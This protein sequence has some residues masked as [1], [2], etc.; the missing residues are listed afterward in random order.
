MI[1]PFW[2]AS[3]S[4]GATTRRQSGGIFSRHDRRAPT[5]RNRLVENSPGVATPPPTTTT[6]NLETEVSRLNEESAKKD[7]II[8]ELEAEK[9]KMDKRITNLELGIEF[10]TLSSGLGMT[11]TDLRALDAEYE[12]LKLDSASV[13]SDLDAAQ[14]LATS[15]DKELKDVR[16]LLQN[17]E[18]TVEILRAEN[19][20]LELSDSIRRSREK[21]LEF[22]RCKL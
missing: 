22:R 8:R 21:D 5:S 7:D 6:R 9:S 4:I 20:K 18:D 13:E 11:K 2:T 14:Q 10:Q 17:A 19:S 15:L 1:P 16:D 3:Q 12:N